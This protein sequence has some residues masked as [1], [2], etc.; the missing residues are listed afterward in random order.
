MSPQ[1]C[2]VYWDMSRCLRTLADA[3]EEHSS[4]VQV[5]IPPLVLLL[6]FTDCSYVHTSALSKSAA[7]RG[8]GEQLTVAV[9]FH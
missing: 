4:D 7:H 1:L 2:F 8:A 3:L 6:P 9:K 5:R